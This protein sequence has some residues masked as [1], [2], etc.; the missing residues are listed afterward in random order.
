VGHSR[1]TATVRHVAAPVL[2]LA[3]AL[4]AVGPADAAG[5]GAIAI[6]GYGTTS[7]GLTTTPTYQDSVTFT[8]TWTGT[9]VAGDAVDTAS[10][11][12]T[13][14]GSGVIAETT[15]QSQ[16]TTSGTCSGIGLSGNQVTASCTLNHT[17]FT[18]M[19]FIGACTLTVGVRSAP[20][21]LGGSTSWVPGQVNP[22]T[23]FTFQGGAALAGA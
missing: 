23:S 4:F 9:F 11:W 19:I 18:V 7:P 1:V 2:L 6:V 13:F 8:M 17:K 5:G 21:T 3:A 14:S 12:C 15:L 22:I 16:G 20:V 10:L